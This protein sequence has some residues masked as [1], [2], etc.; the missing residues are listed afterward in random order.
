MLNWIILRNDPGQINIHE[1]DHG[2]TTGTCRQSSVGHLLIRAEEEMSNSMHWQKQLR[3]REK[4]SSSYHWHSHR[5]NQ[6]QMSARSAQRE[7]LFGPEK[8]FSRAANL[9]NGQTFYQTYYAQKHT[10]WGAAEDNKPSKEYTKDIEHKDTRTNVAESARK[11]RRD[12]PYIFAC[13]EQFL[14]EHTNDG[15]STH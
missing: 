7:Q 12:S 5:C 1:I 10:S 9:A 2:N 15:S 3:N 6:D 11:T 8:S 4:K 13:I 14:S